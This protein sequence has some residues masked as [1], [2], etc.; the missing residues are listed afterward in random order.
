MT[1]SA[2]GP[3]ARAVHRFVPVVLPLGV[4]AVAGG[5]LPS[6]EPRTYLAV[7]AAGTVV[8]VLA[9]RPRPAAPPAPATPPSRWWPWAGPAAVFGVLEFWALLFPAPDRP[10]FSDLL[11]PLLADPVGRAVGWFAWLLTGWWL[12]RRR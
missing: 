6:F 9:L 11:D 12:V 4:L 10:T 5:G 2:Q 3:A 1:P 7:A 8:A